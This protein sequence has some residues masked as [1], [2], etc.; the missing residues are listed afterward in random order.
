MMRTRYALLALLVLPG[1]ALAQ[2]GGGGGG[3]G[4]DRGTNAKTDRAEMDKEFAP[5][6]KLSRGDLEDIV[7]AKVLLDKKKDLKLTDDQQK[8]LKD[9]VGKVK[10]TNTPLYAA[11]DSLRIVVRPKSNPTDED[12]VRS[13]IA[14]EELL[15][16]VRTIRS[17]YD[18]S[19]KD[20]VALLDDSQKTMAAGILE[21]LTK[22]AESMISD[23]L[24][25]G[26][27]MRAGARP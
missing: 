17:N 11:F 3:G 1:V 19:A 12:Q 16:V 4:R 22:D 15:S 21:K 25:G 7:P 14:R 13:T 24:N 9:Q 6:M 5:P 26:R 2:R 18:A 20:A 27:P 23:R 10:E 8:Q